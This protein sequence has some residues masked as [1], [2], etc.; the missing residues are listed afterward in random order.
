MMSPLVF[1]IIGVTA[2][3]GYVQPAP[4]VGTIQATAT[5]TKVEG[6]LVLREDD[7][8][9]VNIPLIQIPSGTPTT[10]S[11]IVR[12]SDTGQITTRAA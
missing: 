9:T 1:T 2:P 3:G 7:Q 8:A 5:K 10:V 6:S 12:V 4:L 11:M